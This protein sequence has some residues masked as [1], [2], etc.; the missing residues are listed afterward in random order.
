MKPAAEDLA[1]RR[2]VWLAFSEL[3][4]DTDVEA[5][6]PSLAHDLA[7]SAYSEAEL[8]R[9]LL[10]E[11]QPLLQWNLLSVAGVWDGFDPGWLEQS[12]LARRHRLRLPFLFPREE[13]RQLALFIREARERP[14]AA[15]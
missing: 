3:F 13:W 14:V 11:V 5:L 8:E 7:G 9:I 6:L 1:Q 15:G 12:I 10:E 4:L 2:P